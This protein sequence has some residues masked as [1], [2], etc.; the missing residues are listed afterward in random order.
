MAR[1]DARDYVATLQQAWKQKDVD[2]MVS[3]VADDIRFTDPTLEGPGHGKEAYRTWVEGWFGAFSDVSIEPTQVVEKG[4]HLAFMARF[5]AKHTGPLASAEGT[6]EPSGKSVDFPFADFITFGDDG[7]IH[8]DH[9]VE[10]A[11]DI[12][13]QLR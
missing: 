9:I 2:R 8:A 10:D 5:K 4:N 7:R 1:H 11:S 12:A 3:M 13:E 6:L